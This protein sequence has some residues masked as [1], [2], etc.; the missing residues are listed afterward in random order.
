MPRVTGCSRDP[1]PPARMIPFIRLILSGDFHPL[2]GITVKQTPFEGVLLIEAAV[3]EDERG[4]FMESW[5]QRA[6]AAAGVPHAFVQDAHSRSK[7]G[8]IR[9]IHYQDMTAPL[10]KLVRCTAGRIYDVAVDLREG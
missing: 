7:R 2:M 5:N 1:A 6:Y 4:F 8:V 3:F 10:A 9:G